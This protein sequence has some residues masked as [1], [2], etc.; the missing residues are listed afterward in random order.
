ML[1]FH[2]QNLRN[3][4]FLEKP[5][6]SSVFGHV[7]EKIVKTVFLLDTKDPMNVFQCRFHQHSMSTITSRRKTCKTTLEITFLLIVI[8]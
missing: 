2:C 8:T 4:F 6:F 1:A 5:Q 3:M 7:M